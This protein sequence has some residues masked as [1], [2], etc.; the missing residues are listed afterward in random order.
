VDGLLAFTQVGFCCVYVVFLAEQVAYWLPP[1]IPWQAVVLGWY[2]VLVLLSW[3][4]TLQVLSYVSLLATIVTS[5]SLLVIYGAAFAFMAENIFDAPD[6]SSTGAV[7]TPFD[8]DSDGDLDTVGDWT[9]GVRWTTLSI[10][11]GIAVY[12]YEAIGIVL[13]I[14]TSY[15]HP[16][17]YEKVLV[18]CLG[19]STVNY[20]LFGSVC[21]LAWGIAVEGDILENLGEF[22]EGRGLWE[23]LMVTVQLFLV[24]CIAGSYPLQLFVFTDILEHWLLST[25]R[26]GETH[27]YAKQNAIRALIVAAT[28]LVAV[29]VPSFSLLMAIIGSLGSASLQFI[30]PALFMLLIAWSTLPWPSRLLYSFYILLGSAGGAFGFVQ[31]MVEVVG[32]Y[33]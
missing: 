18:A 4:R 20:V 21:Y 7:E 13:P 15:Q 25:G 12:S 32:L 6:T 11:F 2:P 9:W 27:L 14:E 30:F 31:A 17:R 26:L 3:I 1:S 16:N 22:A 28:C 5:F 24:F 19:A 29:A 23:I 33:L 8:F 10:S